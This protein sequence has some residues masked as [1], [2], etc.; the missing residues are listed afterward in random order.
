[1]PTILIGA[2]G[3]GAFALAGLSQY[4]QHKRAKAQGGCAGSCAGCS[5]SGQCG[6]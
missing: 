1:M 6:L 2:V 4:R 3:L 5:S